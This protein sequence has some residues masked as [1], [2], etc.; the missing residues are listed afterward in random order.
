MCYI[1]GELQNRMNLLGIATED[2]ASKAFMDVDSINGI[3]NNEVAFEE[4]DEFDLSLI[5]SVLHCQPEYFYDEKVRNRDLLVS[6]MNRGKDNNKSMNVKAKLQDFISDFAFLN[7]V[8]GEV[9]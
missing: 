3:I 5:C 1:G 7:E 6:T 9:E 8:L 4:I 2:L